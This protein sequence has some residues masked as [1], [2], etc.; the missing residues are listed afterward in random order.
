M[1]YTPP[2]NDAVSFTEAGTYSSPQNDAVNFTEDSGETQNYNPVSTLLDTETTTS[3]VKIS[4]NAVSTIDGVSNVTIYSTVYS[5]VHAYPK[6]TESVSSKS[7]RV[8]TTVTTTEETD[9]M[10]S[11]TERS[12]EVGGTFEDV[13]DVHTTPHRYRNISPTIESTDQLSTEVIE[14]FLDAIKK[15]N[16]AT[17]T[18]G[19]RNPATG[20]FG[21]ENPAE[22]TFD[23]KNE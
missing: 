12:V 18:F 4:R 9:S 21:V 7:E 14:L 15:R 11:S 13:S 2:D 5:R 6:D 23:T 3:T 16:P 22:G 20:T 10:D 17:G 19:T 1:S 8:R